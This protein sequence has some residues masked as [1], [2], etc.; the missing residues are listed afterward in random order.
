MQPPGVAHVDE[1]ARELHERVLDQVLCEFAVAG[2]QVR[3]SAGIRRMP[4]V[5]LY[6]EPT[7]ELDRPGLHSHSL[8][9]PF[10]NARRG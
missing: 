4:F 8:G 1:P 2:E 6:E 3:E 5:Q 7:L 10:S 9:P